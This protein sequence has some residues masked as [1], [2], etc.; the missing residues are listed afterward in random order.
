MQLT[1]AAERH[2]KLLK[3]CIHPSMRRM[4]LQAPALLQQTWVWFGDRKKLLTFMSRGSNLPLAHSWER[5]TAPSG[6][7][8][9]GQS[10]QG[11]IP[12]IFFHPELWRLDLC[13]LP[14]WQCQW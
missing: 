1:S 9:P 6:Y 5:A 4:W 8:T 2:S 11:M 3:F 12:E 14:P 13:N 10:Q 7:R